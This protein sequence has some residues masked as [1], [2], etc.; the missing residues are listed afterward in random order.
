MSLQV[1]EQFTTTCN[2]LQQPAAGAMILGV[3]RQVLSEMIDTIRET[4][5]LH[6]GAAGVFIM[7]FERIGILE[8]DLAHCVI[9]IFYRPPWPTC[10][11]FGFGSRESTTEDGFGK[12]NVNF[13]LKPASHG[14][15]ALESNS[16]LGIAGHTIH[17][18]R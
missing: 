16:E 9:F 15:S 17:D 11:Y 6:I 13:S 14:R 18:N 10:V 8:N 2:H 4:N 1:V 5:H 3:C 7:Q 12:E